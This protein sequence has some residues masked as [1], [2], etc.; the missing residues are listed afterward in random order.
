MQPARGLVKTAL[1]MDRAP[2]SPGGARP[3]ILR[4]R[5]GHPGLPQRSNKEKTH[6]KM[7]NEFPEHRRADPRRQAEMEVYDQLAGSDAPGAAIYEIRAN[8]DA[9]EVD[10]AVWIEDVARFGIQVKG[11][12]YTVEGGKWFLYADGERNPMQDPVKLTWDAAMSIRAALWTKGRYKVYM[13]SVLLFP[14][15]PEPDPQI[16]EWAD[17]CKVNPLWGSENLVQRL[18]E[19]QDVEGIYSPPTAR[20]IEAEVAVLMP[21]LAEELPGAAAEGPP[22]ADPPAMGLTARQVVIQHAG[23]VNVYTVGVAA[24]DGGAVPVAG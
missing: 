14:D 17:N 7:L 19:V 15:M 1:H 6:M 9:P 22:A 5:R 23:V 3:D 11:G 10:F 16:Q 12:R 18:T 24:D 21:G 4:S 8:R 2:S 13:V 20:H